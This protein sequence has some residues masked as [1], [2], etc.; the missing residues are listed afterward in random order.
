M[1]DATRDVGGLSDRMQRAA[2][3]LRGTTP[4]S[5]PPGASAAQ[6]I[7]RQLDRLADRLGVAT[8]AKDDDARK[9]SEQLARTEELRDKLQQ[10]G[11]ALEN[12]GRENGRAGGTQRAKRP[13]AR[14]DGPAKAGRARA[15]PT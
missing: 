1:R 2:D 15:G 6:E 10:M 8:G 7:A 3:E 13:P 12:A 14:A 9:L 11:Q 4:A 5:R